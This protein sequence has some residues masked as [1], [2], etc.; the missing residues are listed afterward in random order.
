LKSQWLAHFGPGVHA[1]CG[2]VVNVR[3]GTLTRLSQIGGSSDGYR[4]AVIYAAVERRGC[5][6][7]AWNPT[8]AREFSSTFRRVERF[9][10]MPVGGLL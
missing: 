1:I 3:H 8:S 7:H 5:G 9:Q 2:S 10:L 4:V 6:R